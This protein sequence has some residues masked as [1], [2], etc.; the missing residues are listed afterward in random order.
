MSLAEEMLEDRQTLKSLELLQ[1]K[2][3][4]NIGIGRNDR[5]TPGTTKHF[6]QESKSSAQRFHDDTD[7]PSTFSCYDARNFSRKDEDESNGEA[8]I[9]AQVNCSRLGWTADKS[10][11]ELVQ[12]NSYQFIRGDPSTDLSCMQMT[13]Q[14]TFDYFSQVSHSVGFANLYFPISRDISPSFLLPP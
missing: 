3:Q 14:P 2:T 13:Q 1:D 8:I 7:K 12:E 6:D 11:R 4:V 9:D 5:L 10:P